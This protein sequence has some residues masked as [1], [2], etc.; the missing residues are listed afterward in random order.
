MTPRTISMS[1]VRPMQRTRGLGAPARARARC[2]TRRGRGCGSAAAARRGG[3]VGEHELARGAVVD[4]DRLAGCRVDQLGVDEAAGAEV[5][6]VLLLALAPERDADVAD[7]HRLGHARAPAVLELGA[8]GGLAA[9]GLA[10]DE[11]PLDA[12]AGE[13]DAALGRPLDQVGGVGG[14]ERR[15]LG[16]QQLDRLHQPLGVAGA[17]R[18]VAEADAVERR[19]ARRRRRTARRCRSRRGA[20]RPRRPRRRSCAPSRSTQLSRSSRGQRDVARRA[21]GAAGRVDADDLGAASR[22]GA[23]RSGSRACTVVA[24]LLLVGQRQRARSRP[25]RRPPRR[26]RTPAAASFVAVERR[27]L[28]QVGELVAVARSS[29]ASCSAHGRVSTS[30]SSISRPASRRLVGRRPPRPPPPSGSR[31]AARAPRPGGR[32]GPRC[33]RGS[34][35]T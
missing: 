35:P 18:D 31:S 33:A 8:E 26:R 20:G 7:P 29:S 3:E 12:G 2:G 6:A 32:A 4:L 14:R 28:E 1:S 34:A 17:D 5:H 19:R 10:G 13:V 16:P 9:A 15:G 11:H 23:R 24:Q 30:G 22:R 27:A 25:G 21:G